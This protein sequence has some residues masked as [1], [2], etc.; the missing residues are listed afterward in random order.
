MKRY[1]INRK[2]SPANYTLESSRTLSNGVV[3]KLT[4]CGKTLTVTAVYEQQ[5]ESFDGLNS[6]A[7]AAYI[8]DYLTRKYDGVSP[9]DLPALTA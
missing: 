1:T 6:V 7:E 2:S 8:E 4:H 3:L 5:L 9:E